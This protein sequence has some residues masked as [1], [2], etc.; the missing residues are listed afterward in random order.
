MD[1]TFADPNIQHTDPSDPTK[2]SPVPLRAKA[3]QIAQ[4]AG[5]KAQQIKQNAVEKAGQLREYAG[6]KAHDIK[7]TA[8]VKS[9]QIK[10]A[11]EE[12]IQHGQVRAREAHADTEEYIRQHPTKSV[13]TALGVGILIGL[14]IRR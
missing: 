3:G 12:Q 7:E 14:V 13:L 11:A 9:Q 5:T 8:T 1:E 2:T 4:D 10:Q 6:T